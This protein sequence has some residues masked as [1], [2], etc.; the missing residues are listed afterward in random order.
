MGVLTLF[1]CSF[2]LL[3]INDFHN[4]EIKARY[5]LYTLFKT[6]SL[7]TGM[8]FLHTAYK[9]KENHISQYTISIRLPN[10]CVWVCWVFFF[11][12]RVHFSSLPIVIK[13]L[14]VQF[15]K[16]YFNCDLVILVFSKEGLILGLLNI[17]IGNAKNL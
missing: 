1:I 9:I 11:R 16:I 4:Y 2:L 12:E 5:L 7:F 3:Y 17:K 14:F 6:N 8:V 15:N 10:C 13:V